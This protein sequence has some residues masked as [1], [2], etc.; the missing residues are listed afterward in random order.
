MPVFFVEFMFMLCLKGLR[1]N[2]EDDISMILGLVNL[3]SLGVI[4]KVQEILEGL[5]IIYCN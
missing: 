3:Y 2:N 4:V 1:N 5:V